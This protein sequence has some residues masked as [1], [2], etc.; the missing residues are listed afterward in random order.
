MD[1]NPGLK[2]KSGKIYTAIQQQEILDYQAIK[3]NEDAKKENV[4]ASCEKKTESCQIL[5]VI[6]V[7]QEDQL[8]HN[9]IDEELATKE[10]QNAIVKESNILEP[11]IRNVA[12]SEENVEPKESSKALPVDSA[13]RNTEAL[14]ANLRTNVETVVENVKKM[15]A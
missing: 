3:A 10:V 13:S 14:V 6:T 7:P 11:N 5:N 12:E 4:Q 1:D 9:Q 8:F 2:S 15:H